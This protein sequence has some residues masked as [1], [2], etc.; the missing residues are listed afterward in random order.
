MKERYNDVGCVVE[1]LSAD[2]LRHWIQNIGSRHKKLS[3]LDKA[4]MLFAGTWIKD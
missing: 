1:G 3:K 4:L 2:E